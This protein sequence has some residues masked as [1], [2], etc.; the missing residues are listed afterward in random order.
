MLLVV[1]SLILV[2][3]PFPVAQ[4]SSFSLFGLLFDFDGMPIF[5]TL[6][7]PGMCSIVVAGE[8]H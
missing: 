4:M 7:R 1:L 8:V 5:V 3:G 2:L 6:N